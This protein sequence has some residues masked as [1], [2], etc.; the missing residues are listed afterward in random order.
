MD[1]SSATAAFTDHPLELTKDKRL[2]NVI[3][4]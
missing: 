4:V 2:S 1:I 3:I